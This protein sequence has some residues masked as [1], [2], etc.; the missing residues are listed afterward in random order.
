MFSI[1]KS[2]VLATVILGSIALVI[3]P[4]EAQYI[5]YGQQ[6]ATKLAEWC[7]SNA[8]SCGRLPI[9]INNGYQQIRQY[10]P[11]SQEEVQRLQRQ[12]EEYFRMRNNNYRNSGYR[13]GR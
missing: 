5:Q 9:T 6:G 12:R 1:G 4:A 13:Y 8:E 2:L 10:Q 3:K 11:P 7:S